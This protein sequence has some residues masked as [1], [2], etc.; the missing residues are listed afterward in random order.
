MHPKLE[1]ALSRWLK[2]ELIDAATADRL[3]AFEAE[4]EQ[5]QK[6]RWPVLLA[7]SLGGILLCSGVLL[8]VAAH[9]EDLS[10]ASRFSLV[11]LTVA[12]FHFSGALLAEILPVLAVVLHAV[13]TVCLGAGIFLA[14]QIFNLQEHWPGGL[15][16]WAIGA[17][18]GWFLTRHWV[19]A[20]FAALLTPA[21]L[22]GEWM[23]ATKWMYGGSQIA[24]QSLLLLAF[25]YL[26]A[27]ASEKTGYARRALTWIGGISLIPCTVLVLE[28]RLF[29][30]GASNPPPMPLLVVGWLLGFGL[31]ISLAYF[32]RGR[33]A[34]MNLL[35]ALWVAVLG[36]VDASRRTSGDLNL[37]TFLWRELGA[38]LWCG[39]GSV[40]LCAWG[41]KEARRE[42]I[43]LGIL[44]F[45]IT[46]LSF[47][48]S[49]AM[50]KLSRSASM[51]G[52]GLLFLLGGWTL[53]KT[54]RRLVARLK[55]RGA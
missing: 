4:H 10:P 16:L 39:L 8:F 35:A 43:N 45:G 11:L 34:R 33:A 54:R 52:L 48:F 29:W 40:A 42:R 41:L 1:G 20:A 12:V 2:A 22:V 5:P 47:Y 14:G 51:I 18:A 46:V 24:Y 30:N 38:Y 17:W 7:S 25:T 55:E 23:V 9:W 37:L 19:Q 6:F 32:L 50:D 13:G 21:W 27:Y 36:T 28:S 44:G 3:R 26:S 15:M 31:P 49:N 53:E